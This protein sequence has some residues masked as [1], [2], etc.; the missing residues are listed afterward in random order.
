VPESIQVFYNDEHAMLLGV[1]QISVKTSSGTTTTNYPVSPLLTNPGSK[2]NPDTGATEAQGGTDTSGRPMFPAL[3]I[4]DLDVPPGSNNELAGDWQYG[5]TGIPPTKIFGTWKSATKTID[6]TKNPTVVTVT[7]DNDPAVNNW[8]LGPGADPVPPGLVNQGYGIEIRWDI[9]TLNLIPGHRYR[10]YFMLHDGDQNKT[11]GDAG[12]SCGY[13]TMPGG[14]PSPTPSA[15]PTPTPTPAVVVTNKTFGGT[16]AKTVTVTFQN[17]TAIGQVLTALT[18]NW[19]Q[20]TNG[21]LT[22]ITMGGTTIYNTSTGG[23]SLTTSSL[24]GTTAQRT[25]AVG[26]SATVTFTFQNNVSTNANN[27]PGGSA[28]FNPFGTVMTFP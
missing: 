8:N 26:A 3:F 22:K 14:T 1:R 11:G 27:Y 7:T 12:Q 10:V 28:T 24:L 18:I 9:N 23:G 20:A 4:T 17:Q 13:F 21:N 2:T 5:G 6:Q 16:Q 19:P 25:I 15:S